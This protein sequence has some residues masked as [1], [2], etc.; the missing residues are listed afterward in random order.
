MKLVT[1]NCAMALKK[2]THNLL[3]LNGDIITVQECSEKSIDELIAIGGWSGAWFGANRNKGLGILARLPWKIQKVEAANMNFASRVEIEGP[4][5]FV[6]YAIWASKGQDQEGNYIRQVHKL[7]DEIELGKSAPPA[8]IMGDF[9]SNANFDGKRSRNHSLAVKRLGDLGLQS[10]YH[11]F[12]EEAHGE[13]KQRTLY[14]LKNRQK[15]YH[16]DY[17]FL[18]EFLMDGLKEVAVGTC[19]DWLPLSD[20]APIVVN[21]EIPKAA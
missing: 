21:I 5:S 12:F 19:D 16:I 3:S 14:L 20:H 7:L 9:N 15:S 1:W 11:K 10:A 18:S 2:K 13:E 4:T 8:I 17:V 6:L